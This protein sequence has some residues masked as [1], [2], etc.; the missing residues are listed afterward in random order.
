MIARLLASVG[1][2]VAA[3]G[4]TILGMATAESV[5]NDDQLNLGLYLIIGGMI[6]GIVGV[7]MY[8]ASEA[9]S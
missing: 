4:F 5:R 1:F 9:R 7:I 3:V 2:P 8:R 6:A